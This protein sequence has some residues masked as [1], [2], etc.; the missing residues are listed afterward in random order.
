MISELSRSEVYPRFDSLARCYRAAWKEAGQV[1]HLAYEGLLE[2]TRL[3]LPGSN[4]GRK[5][6][7]A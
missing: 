2:A 6:Q 4:L 5:V 7:A 1:L 3:P